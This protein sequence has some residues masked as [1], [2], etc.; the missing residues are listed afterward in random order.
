MPLER[1][2]SAF[3]CPVLLEPF[4]ATASS[5]MAPMVLPCGHTLSRRALTQ[6]CA[7]R[8][9]VLSMALF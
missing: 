9:W 2:S 1:Q 5:D 8:A 3:S 7:G 6:V 4:T